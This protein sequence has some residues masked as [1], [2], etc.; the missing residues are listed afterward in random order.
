M[1]RVE[2]E[3]REMGLPCRPRGRW[4]LAAVNC[5][6]FSAWNRSLNPKYMLTPPVEADDSTMMSQ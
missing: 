5:R 3:R 2:S 1:G 6:T 4:L